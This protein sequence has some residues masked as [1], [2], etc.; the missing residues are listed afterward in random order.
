MLTDRGFPS[1]GAQKDSA[2][3]YRACGD[4]CDTYCHTPRCPAVPHSRRAQPAGGDA[5]G[6]RHRRDDA[7]ALLDDMIEGGHVAQLVGA[8]RVSLEPAINLV[9]KV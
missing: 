9:D 6:H 2:S 3:E 7:E 8:R 1:G 4:G 5:P